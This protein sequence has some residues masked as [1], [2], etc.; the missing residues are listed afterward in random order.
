MLDEHA[1]ISGVDMAAILAAISNCENGKQ[2]IST[3]D[4]FFKYM[5]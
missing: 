3:P 4:G 5:M 2:V 1:R